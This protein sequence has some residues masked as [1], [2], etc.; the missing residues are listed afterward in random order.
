MNE[1]AEIC[2]YLF[3]MGYDYHGSWSTNAGP[4]APLTGNDDYSSRNYTRTINEDYAGIDRNK[5]ILGVPYYGAKWLV[6]NSNPYT[7]VIPKNQPDSN[8]IGHVDYKNVDW[9]SISSDVNFD[10]ISQTSYYLTPNGS[11]YNLLWIDNAS[12]LF[13]K[14]DFILDQQLKGVGIWSLG[15]DGNHNE[16]WNLIEEKFTDS[17]TSVN[18]ENLPG[19]FVL[20]QNY[21]NPF[22]PTTSIEY[23]VASI[24]KISI[25]VYDVLGRENKILINEVKSP[26]NYS[27][28]FD[29]SNLSSG[30][31][32]YVLEA[33]EVRLSK[34]MLLLQIS[35]THILLNNREKNEKIVCTCFSSI[36]NLTPWGKVVLP[37]LIY[38]FDKGPIDWNNMPDLSQYY[39]PK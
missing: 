34:K 9:S 33:G 38:S 12:S 10:D 17:T 35:S 7:S 15:K 37:R 20:H 24:E 2:D 26:G 8:W 1:L 29:A 16:L 19:E 5:L 4:V 23:Q 3:I 18:D 14:Y 30:V 13:F 25:R 22:N 11:N 6:D 32:F 31:Y 39:L 21:P 36:R 28:E 27:V